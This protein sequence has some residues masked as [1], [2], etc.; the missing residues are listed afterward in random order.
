M[1]NFQDKLEAINHIT[2]IEKNIEFFK[3]FKG[4]T[5]TEKFKLNKQKKKFIILLNELI[6]NG[7]Y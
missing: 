6:K 7:K 4:D 2:I 3:E 1:Y 5:A